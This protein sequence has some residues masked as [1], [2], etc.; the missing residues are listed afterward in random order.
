[1]GQQLQCSDGLAPLQPFLFTSAVCHCLGV[2]GPRSSIGHFHRAPPPL[3][4]IQVE[5]TSIML[6]QILIIRFKLAKCS[7]VGIT[8]DDLK[9]SLNLLSL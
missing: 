4:L 7:I 3:D 5:L 9:F 8:D 6:L 1:M 2:H